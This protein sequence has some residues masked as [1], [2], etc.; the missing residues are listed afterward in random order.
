MKP[1]KRTGRHPFPDSH[2]D[3][4]LRSPPPLL[5][6]QCGSLRPPIC[7]PAE[8]RKGTWPGL[9]NGGQLTS[10]SSCCAVGEQLPGEQQ[11]ANL[12]IPQL[13]KLARA[14]A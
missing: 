11:S 5:D 10:A 4:E 9:S 8:C 13:R 14:C 1:L 7:A 3:K 6:D 2:R 12:A